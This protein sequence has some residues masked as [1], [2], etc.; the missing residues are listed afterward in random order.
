M[1]F[2]GKVAAWMGYMEMFLTNKHCC[3]DNEEF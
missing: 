3:L 2:T 1:S